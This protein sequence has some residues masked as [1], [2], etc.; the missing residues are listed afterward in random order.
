M[1]SGNQRAATCLPEKER[2]VLDFN[3]LEDPLREGRGGVQG[4]FGTI[5]EGGE[6]R[7]EGKGGVI[8]KNGDEITSTR[9][10]PI[11][12]EGRGRQ[13]KRNVQPRPEK[14]G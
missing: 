2:G 11:K 8:S 3:G 14:G 13:N 4:D 1:E 10:Q 7:I 12:G 6:A 9:L 5:G